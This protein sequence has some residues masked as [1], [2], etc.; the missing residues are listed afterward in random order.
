MG[1]EMCI[2]DSFLSNTF[3]SVFGSGLTKYLAGPLTGILVGLAASLAGKIWGAVSSV[4][5]GGTAGQARDMGATRFRNTAN[6]PQFYRQA[7]DGN[8]YWYNE[9]GTLADNQGGDTSSSG[10][11]TGSGPDNPGS[12]AMGG[13][14]KAGEW[15]WVGEQGPELV[16]FGA[17]GTVIPNHEVGNRP[18][19]VHSTIML[20][21][22]VAARSVS[23]HLPDVADTEGY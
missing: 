12:N 10:S 6:G 3:S 1:S 19:V 2:R 23:R 5:S 8:W 15:S 22:E 7:T 21:G 13:P 9:D 14:V 16:Q 18:I 11:G 17:P 20:D 4:F